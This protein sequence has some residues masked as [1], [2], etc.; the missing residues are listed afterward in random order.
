MDPDELLVSTSLVRG[1]HVCPLPPVPMEGNGVVVEISAKSTSDGPY[2]VRI[3]A[4]HSA[5]ESAAVQPWV[6]HY[7]PVPAVP[8]L[9]ERLYVVCGVARPTDRPH[10]RLR[11]YLHSGE[12][13]KGH[14]RVG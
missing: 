6:G 2:V 12:S 8:V 13:I 1:G 10:I 5:Q 4:T 9:S 14:A 7:A 3:G 11:E